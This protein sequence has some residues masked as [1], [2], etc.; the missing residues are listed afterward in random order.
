VP[1][2]M[3]RDRVGGKHGVDEYRIGIRQFRQQV[4]PAGLPTTTVW[5]YGSTAHEHTFMTPSCTINAYADRPVRVTW[6]NQLVDRQGRFLPHL[7]PV[8][9]TLH[10]A[11]PSGGLEGRD[12]M[13]M[14]TSTP[15]P[16][17]GPVPMVVHLHGGHTTEENDGYPEAWYLPV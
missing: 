6:I 15:G 12:C 13:P 10:W 1:A 16:Y 9:P 5:G 2:A 7:L 11:N 14:F 4:L 8:D 17:D 3:P